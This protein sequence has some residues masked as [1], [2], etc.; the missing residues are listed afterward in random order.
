MSEIW[1]ERDREQP[2][3]ARKFRKHHSGMYS[4][5]RIL[6]GADVH[7]R[8]DAPSDRRVIEKAKQYGGIGTR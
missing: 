3:A 7:S 1:K 4:H 8:I 6:D 5:K 2:N